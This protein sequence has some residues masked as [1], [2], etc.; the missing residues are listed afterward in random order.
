M[1]LLTATAPYARIERCSGFTEFSL[2]EDNT[3]RKIAHISL[4]KGFAHVVGVCNEVM[5]GFQ[6]VLDMRGPDFDFVL[7]EFRNGV[8]NHRDDRN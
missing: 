4:I 3:G 8:S 1:K 7:Q 2:V 6:A 5:E